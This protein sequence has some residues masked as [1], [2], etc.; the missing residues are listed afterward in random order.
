MNL[1]KLSIL[2]KRDGRVITYYAS[3]I[4]PLSFY[5]N[6]ENALIRKNNPQVNMIHLNIQDTAE[7]TN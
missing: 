6:C 5:F 1:I 3:Y 7:K 2:K 4:V